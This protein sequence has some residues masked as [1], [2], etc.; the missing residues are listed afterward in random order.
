MF[1]PWIF[2]VPGQI[3]KIQTAFWT[4]RPGLVEVIQAADTILGSLPQPSWL[5][6]V[7]SVICLQAFALIIWQIWKKRKDPNVQFMSLLVFLPGILLFITSYVMRPV[8]VPRAIISSGVGIYGLIGILASTQIRSGLDDKAKRNPAPALLSSLVI[9]ASLIS[10][11]YQYVYGRFSRSPFAELDHFLAANCTPKT[12]CLI[13]HDNKL[14][15]FPAFVYN[16]NLNQR[17]M[18]DAPDTFNDTLALASQEAMHQMA[19][20]NLLQAVDDYGQVFFVTF[21]KALDEYSAA[22]KTEH[23]SI[24]ELKNQYQLM[25]IT[26]IGDLL[27]Y[28]FVR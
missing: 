20:T 23:P 10:L 3:H 1:L 2:M 7:L 21:Q 22:G 16:R 14:S 27:V 24:A 17:F 12:D 5:V 13:L 9:L 6:I 25:K 19:F 15:Y 4:P 18:A 28:E 26:P 8:Y 11:P